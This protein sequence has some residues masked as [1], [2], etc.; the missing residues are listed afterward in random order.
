MGEMVVVLS[1]SGDL[2]VVS[3]QFEDLLNTTIN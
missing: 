1:V 3:D 2:V